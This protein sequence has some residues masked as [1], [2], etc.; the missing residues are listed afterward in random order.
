MTSKT[1]DVIKGAHYYDKLSHIWLF[2][3]HVW[4]PGE[5]CRALHRAKSLRLF[6]LRYILEQDRTKV[7]PIENNT[8]SN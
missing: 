7:C 5:L 8:N 1:V 3:L 2:R 6:H 4:Q